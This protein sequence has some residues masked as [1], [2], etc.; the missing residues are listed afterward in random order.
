MFVTQSW[1]PSFRFSF[2]SHYSNS[3]FAGSKAFCETLL[4]PNSCSFLDWS[5]GTCLLPLQSSHA[6]TVVMHRVAVLVLQK[7]KLVCLLLSFFFF[8]FGTKG[9]S[10]EY[11]VLTRPLRCFFLHCQCIE[12]QCKCRTMPCMQISYQFHT[13][14]HSC[15]RAASNGDV[16]A[17]TAVISCNVGLLAQEPRC[18]ELLDSF[19]YEK[20]AFPTKMH[21]SSAPG[22]SFLFPCNLR[23]RIVRRGGIQLNSGLAWDKRED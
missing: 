10:A 11:L 19:N 6:L 5:G 3:Y 12:I 15:A 21:F 22:L 23:M 20:L 14:I 17:W 8:F 1:E 2:W 9:L 13:K 16:R 4:Q 18:K 7:F